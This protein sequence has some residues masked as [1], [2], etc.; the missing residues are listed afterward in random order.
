M[1]K[2]LKKDVDFVCV[3]KLTFVKANLVALN[4]T[5]AGIEV[6]AKIIKLEIK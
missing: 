4:M 6:K 5:L 1:K 3:D 2:F